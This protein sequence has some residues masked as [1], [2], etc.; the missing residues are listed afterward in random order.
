M[1]CSRGAG[2]GAE[3]PVR[4]LDLAECGPAAMKGEWQHAPLWRPACLW[5]AA[6][7]ARGIPCSDSQ[8]C[9]SLLGLA[10]IRS[11]SHQAMAVVRSTM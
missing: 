11:S 7:R 1:P 4:I 6:S 8:Q 3:L 10:L 5:T 9:A 2:V